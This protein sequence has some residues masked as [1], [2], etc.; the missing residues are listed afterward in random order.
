[1]NQQGKCPYCNSDDAQTDFR[2]FNSSKNILIITYKCLN[3]DELYQDI[4][5]T[6][7]MQTAK[8]TSFMA[9]RAL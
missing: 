3:C 2:D 1:M 8:L 6:Q 4:Y 9:R 7:Y 5:A